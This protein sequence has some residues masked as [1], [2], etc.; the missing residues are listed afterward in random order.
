MG[1][2]LTATAC[3]AWCNVDHRDQDPDD[4][5]HRGGY[6]WIE[7]DASEP[8]DLWRVKVPDEPDAIGVCAW[9]GA[10]EPAGV[11]VVRPLS[12]CWPTLSPGEARQLAAA[13]MQ[14][15]DAAEV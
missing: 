8:R 4:R 2:N 6:A 3:P 11:T 13:L 5:A 9:Q 1:D 12:G 15:A 10:A 7:L 14:A